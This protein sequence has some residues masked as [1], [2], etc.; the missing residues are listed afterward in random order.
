M[1]HKYLLIALVLSLGL[2]LLNTACG[3]KENKQVSEPEK[4]SGPMML[5]DENPPVSDLDKSMGESKEPMPLPREELQIKAKEDTPLMSAMLEDIKPEEEKEPQKA[6]DPNKPRP[7][8][9]ELPL[10][11]KQRTK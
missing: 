2:L 7:I 6:I 9:E 3:D 11:Q 1:K 5:M 8:P 10:P 4:V